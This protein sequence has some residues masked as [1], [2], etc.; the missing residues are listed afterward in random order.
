[1]SQIKTAG[2]DNQS[3]RL[4]ED[5]AGRLSTVTHVADNQSC[6]LPEKNAGRLSTM[7]RD[8]AGRLSTV[9]RSR[10]S[11]MPSLVS[12][13]ALLAGTV[14]FLLYDMHSSSHTANEDGIVLTMLKTCEGLRQ[15]NARGFHSKESPTNSCARQEDGSYLTGA[16]Q[17]G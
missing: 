11:V 13:G 10:Q 17:R 1:M 15:N 14:A 5:N 2:T 9:T 16:G 8:N 4:Q 12:R 6:R 3:C 7:T